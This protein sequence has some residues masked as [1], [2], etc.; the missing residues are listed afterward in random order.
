MSHC[1]PL[2]PVQQWTNKKQNSEYIFVCCFLPKYH[3]P[4]PYFLSA[5]WLK[6]QAVPPSFLLC[7]RK[8]WGLWDTDTM[9]SSLWRLPGYLL[10]DSSLV[11]TQQLTWGTGTAPEAEYFDPVSISCNDRDTKRQQSR[12]INIFLLFLTRAWILVSYALL[13]GFKKRRHSAGRVQLWIHEYT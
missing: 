5:V 10:G 3:Q 4:S 9:S 8:A 7:L 6:L 13:L 11:A 1:K 2:R 12:R